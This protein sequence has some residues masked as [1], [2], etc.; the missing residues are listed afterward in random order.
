M[1]ARIMPKNTDFLRPGS[2]PRMRLLTGCQQR[3][4]RFVGRQEEGMGRFHAGVHDRL[5]NSPSQ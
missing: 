2:I 5:Q 1:I 4:G 3:L